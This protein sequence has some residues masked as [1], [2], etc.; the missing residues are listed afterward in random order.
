MI[1]KKTSTRS[2][3]ECR[4]PGDVSAV[5]QMAWE[6]RTTFETIYE[7]MGLSEPEVIRLMRAELN[8]SSFRLWRMRMKGRA[9]KH[10]ALRSPDMKFDDH[11]VADHRRANC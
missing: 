1:S 2:L 11:A 5:I 7:R 6:D 10:R 9:T 4:D 8:L 3:S